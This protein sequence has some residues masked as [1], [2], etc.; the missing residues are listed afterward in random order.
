MTD[1]DDGPLESVRFTGLG[2]GPKLI[3]LGAV[4]GNEICGPNAIRRAIAECRSGEIGIRRGEVTFV[5][6]AN[7]KAYRQKTREGDRNLNRDLREKPIPLDYE[8]RIGNRLCALLRQHEVLLDI[9]SFRGEGEP[10]IFFG[11]R[12]NGG[13]LEPFR[14]DAAEAAFAA[15]LGTPVLIHGWLDNYARLI[16]A[17]ERLDL[18]R[19]AITEGYGT[20]E[21]MRFAGGYGVTL[22]CG[23]HD[24]SAAAD[25]GHAA[26]LKALAH[27]QLVDAPPPPQAATTVIEIVDVIVCE[28]PGDRLEGSWKTGDA[29]AAGQVI[30]RRANGE[31]V[32]APRAGFLIFPNATAKPGEGISYL[33]IS[34]GRPLG[35]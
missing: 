2:A 11:P 28:R 16:A 12:N 27:L 8:D 13:E 9:H 34:G 7:P 29:I 10:F 5:P 31:A 20:T 15:C 26:I 6:V 19:L 33:G 18:P 35:G 32:T 24:D 17:R 14:Q 4:H 1:I 3:V 22:E 30:A 23:Q 21:Y 25:V